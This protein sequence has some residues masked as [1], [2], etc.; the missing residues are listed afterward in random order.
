MKIAIFLDTNRNILTV[1]NTNENAAIEQSKKEG[2]TLINDDPAF[3]VSER[4]M[5]T[6]RA[7]DN[8]L[9]HIATGM[10]PDEEKLQATALLGKRVGEAN[11]NAKAAQ[12]LANGAIQS[13][14]QLG[15]MIAPLLASATTEDGGSK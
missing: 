11:V 6:V 13:A 2:W 15:K 12:D 14:A 3:L 7:S 10:T 8:K 5:W 1:N 9:V 4:Y